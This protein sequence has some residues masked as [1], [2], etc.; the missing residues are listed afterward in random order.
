MQHTESVFHRY[1]IN[2]Y[3][4]FS[5]MVERAK[6]EKS[7]LLYCIFSQNKCAASAFN[8]SSLSTIY[9]QLPC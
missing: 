8:D 1:P 9:P 2:A 3:F 4:L 6:L 5:N 7:K